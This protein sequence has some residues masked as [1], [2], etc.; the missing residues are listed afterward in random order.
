MRLATTMRFYDEK[1]KAIFSHLHV[2]HG[3]TILHFF[4]GITRAVTC[5]RSV[6]LPS[7]LYKQTN[8]T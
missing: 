6:P 2:L 8:P 3:L 5:Q 4:S 1:P 7:M